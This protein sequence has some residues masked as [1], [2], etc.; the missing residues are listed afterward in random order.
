MEV[1][2]RSHTQ[3]PGNLD[4]FLFIFFFLREEGHI[5]DEESS[6]HLILSMAATPYNKL[7]ENTMCVD[8]TVDALFLW[9]ARS[10]LQQNEDVSLMKN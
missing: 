1:Q 10:F 5:F 2:Y 7:G 8:D 3:T 6:V 9:P 4:Y